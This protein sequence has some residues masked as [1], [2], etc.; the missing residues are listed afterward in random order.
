MTEKSVWIRQYIKALREDNVPDGLTAIQNI[1]PGRVAEKLWYFINVPY[2]K[3]VEKEFYR[4]CLQL[5]CQR[6]G[7]TFVFEW[8]NQRRFMR[9]DPVKTW[10]I[11]AGVHAMMMLSN[12]GAV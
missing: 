10:H 4:Q 11:Q 1:Y 5:F 6:Y 3:P 12:G 2:V 8:N 9:L 7:F